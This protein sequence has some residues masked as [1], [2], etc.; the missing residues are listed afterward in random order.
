MHGLTQ[1]RRCVGGLWGVFRCCWFKKFVESPGPPVLFSSHWGK[2]IPST[3]GRFS[4]WM[5]RLWFFSV[6]MLPSFL[7]AMLCRLDRCSYHL[8]SPTCGREALAWKEH[9]RSGL[10][11]ASH[12]GIRGISERLDLF[13][14]FWEEPVMFGSKPV[15]LFGLPWKF[16]KAGL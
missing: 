7:L 4:H 16:L 6:M 5:F 8:P 10:W 1:V 3:S 2:E 14:A 9:V 12:N 15:K 13:I 11:T